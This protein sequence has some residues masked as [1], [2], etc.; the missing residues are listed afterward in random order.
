M[1]NDYNNGVTKAFFEV[2]E[3]LSC[4]TAIRTTHR[5]EAHMTVNVERVFQAAQQLSP[6]EQL[7]LIQVISQ[8]LRRTVAKSEMDAIPAGVRRTTPV[9][10]LS[11]LAADFWPEDETVDE[12]NAFVAQQRADDRMRDL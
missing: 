12:I 4:N 1:V 11:I 3:R 6:A 9:W 8:A 10:D 5:E 2:Y 7:E